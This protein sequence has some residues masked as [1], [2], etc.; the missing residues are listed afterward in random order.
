MHS[1][2]FTFFYQAYAAQSGEWWQDI[3]S[4]YEITSIEWQEG[5]VKRV[6]IIPLKYEMTYPDENGKWKTLSD[7]NLSEW[8]TYEVAQ[9]TVI[10][11]ALESHIK[12]SKIEYAN[13]NTIVINSD[14]RYQVR[15][16]KE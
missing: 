5:T 8:R 9:Q 12:Q 1:S 16:V 13:S 10:E 14:N 11:N 3:F 6:S 4:K 7:I 15:C 2:D